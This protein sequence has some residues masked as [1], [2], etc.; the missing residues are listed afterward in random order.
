MRI[1]YGVMGEGL[2][3]AMRSQVVIQHLLEAGHTIEIMASSRAKDFLAEH[4]RQLE[5]TRIHGLHLIYDENRVVRGR[6]LWSNVHAGLAGIPRNIA[7]YFELIDGFR[8]EAVISDFESWVYLYGLTHRLPVLSLDNM[9]ILTR[10]TLPAEI[11]EPHAENFQITK[12]FVKSKLPFCSH[13]IVT[14][15]FR[16]QLRKPR[17]TLVPPLLRRAI[18]SATPSR[19]DHLLVYQTSESHSGLIDALNR[20][21]LEC[22]VYGLK[23]DLHEEQVDGNLRYRPFHEG[24][25]IDDL[26]SARG[27]IAGGGFTLMGE[28]VY[29]RKPMLSVPVRGQ[30]EQVLN[31]RYLAHEGY[32]MIATDLEHPDTVPL[33]VQNL[34]RFEAALACYCQDGNKEALTA[35]D[36]FLERARTGQL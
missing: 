18:L 33:F 27:V 30:F 36:E 32:G 14:T 2:G 26:A 19:G 10:C 29:L 23:R 3:H 13:Y 16:P 6:T 8:P 25:F 20:T 1:L 9:H 31:A 24:R 34:P 11:L 22:R 7:A 4:F 35:V 28:S 15:F 21:G 12:A 17:T 5:V